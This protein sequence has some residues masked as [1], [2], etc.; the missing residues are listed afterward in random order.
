MEETNA[1]I[2]SQVEALVFGCSDV[3]DPAGLEAHLA[4]SRKVGRPL[5]IKLGADPT[6]PDLHLGHVVPLRKLRQF[7][8]MGHIAIFL[9]G[10]FTGMIGDPSGRSKTRPPLSREEINQNADTYRQQVGKILRMDAEHFQLRFNSE[11]SDKM[12]FADVIV[13]ASK[14][15]VA[16]MLERKDFA[17]RLREGRPVSLHEL[18]YPLAQAYDSVALGCD[19]ELGGQDQLFNF[20]VV[21]DI[22]QE[23]GLVPEVVMTVPLLVGTDGRQ[24][25]SKSLGNYI[26]IFEPPDQIFGKIM[27]IPDELLGDYYRLTSGIAWQE[28]ERILGR[29]KDGTL[30][31]RDAK[32]G[33][34]EAVV[35]LYYDVAEARYARS[36]FDRIFAAGELPAD[37]PAVT[38]KFPPEGLWIVELI[39]EGLRC[40]LELPTELGS[41]S[42]IRRKLAAG[43]FKLEGEPITD[44]EARIILTEPAV[45]QYGKRFFV[46]IVP[47][48]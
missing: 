45:L 20:M 19:V 27:S 41:R 11:W 21:R 48:G 13:L 38:V 28:V 30:H 47:V 1:D 8:D 9:I 17:E 44:D 7:Q 31:P 37:M 29:I 39:D 15:T 42:A 26:G 35:A 6:A 12:S 16:R 10:D 5:K 2:H 25:M 46:R 33:L 22:M 40:E 36:E 43:A 34:A 3:I 18:L 23:F 4:H 32:A 24:K 14:Y